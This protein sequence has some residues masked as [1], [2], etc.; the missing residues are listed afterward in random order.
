MTQSAAAIAAQRAPSVLVVLVV[1]D[2]A[3]WIRESLA[4]LAAQTYP[5]L[6]VMAVDNGST[7]GSGELLIQALGE[8][9]V[10][11]LPA[12]RGL[13]GAL[14]AAQAHPVANEADYLLLLH[15]DTAL[16][17]EGVTRMVEAAVGLPGMDRVGV[18]GAKVVDW[19]DPRQL[20][21]VGRSADRF[22]HPYSPLQPG[23][24]DQGQFDRVL[25]VL[26]VSSCAMLISRETWQR[27]GLF[28]ER[29]GAA[30]EDLDFCWRARVAGFRVLMTPLARARHRAAS[31]VADPPTARHHSARF[32]EDRAAIT[33]MLK[34]YSLLSLLWALPLSLGLGFVRL[35]FLLLARRFEEA[36]D[37]LAAWGWNVTHL[38]GTLSRRRKAQK[39]RRVNDRKLHRFMESAGLR[40]PR[41]FETAERMLEQPLDI[42]DD[43]ELPQRRRLRERTASLVATHPV[44][45][46]SFLGVLVGVAAMRSLWSPAGLAGG[47]LPAFPATASAF[48]AEMTS[49]FRTTG[50][51]GSM[52]AS[53]ALGGM[54]ALSAALF[55]ST[56]LAQ[57]AMVGGALPLAAILMY[58]ASVRLTKR[59]GPSVVAA[60]AYVGS[61]LTLWALSQGRLGL[62]V[63]LAVLP[64][65]AERLEVAFGPEGP[66]EQRWRFVAGLGVTLAVL[67]AFLPGAALAVVVLVLVQSLAGAQ[68]RRGLLLILQAAVAAMLLLLPF[69]LTLVSGRGTAFASQVGTTDVG[70]L[71]RLAFGP[72]PGTWSVG[73]FLPIAALIAFALVDAAHRGRAVRAMLAALAGLALA[74]LSAAG[75]LPVPVSDPTAYGA[76]AAVG[77]AMVIAYGLTSVVAW[78]GRESFGLRQIGTALLT[79]VLGAGLLLQALTAMVGGWAVGGPHE[80]PPAWAVVASAAKGD[81]RVLWVGAADGTPFPAPGG[82]PTGVVTAGDATL[83]YSLT[84]RDGVTALDV[85]R[86]LSGPGNAALKEALGQILSGATSHGGALLA[87]FGIRF[88]VADATR[89]PP[90]A[91]ALLQ[92]Q[93]DLDLVP[94]TGLAIYHNAAALP[95]AAILTVNDQ[96][97]AGILAG[98]PLDTAMLGP[99]HAVPMVRAPGGWD[100]PAG[101]GLVALA[102][103]FDG[104]W[105]IHGTDA[106]PQHAFGWATAFTDTKG[107]V[108]VRYGMQ[109]LRSIE[110]GLM[111]ILWAGA[112]WVTR[113]PVRR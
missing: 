12:D 34:N 42:E 89:L 101:S 25:E 84:D 36:F 4:A 39:A 8:G 80:V 76:L 37:L 16:D 103:E 100:G 20:R 52:A 10:V 66:A 85:G 17:P 68:R 51:G 48:F 105:R 92:D 55:G 88:V 95:P 57:K 108:A 26:C 78:L 83:E 109:W 49:G 70:R 54:G 87:P 64:A 97:Q 111:A 43:D 107:P 14:S 19:D 82:D 28:D 90:A 60:A 75:Y 9:R 22:G 63:T 41:W 2:A 56:T 110:V 13:G 38:P 94:A 81:F 113:K 50:L 1:R 72:G 59:Q 27:A 18:V 5:R 104:A 7:D 61:S 44:L 32:E 11:T 21:D 99:L 53:P 15:D 23:E 40:L 73:A 46:A 3:G 30:Y 62:L 6:A 74:W 45:V 35:V 69:V 29:I 65:V 33:A 102:T 77:E 79:V 106:K 67:V 47:V 24:I 98:T 96:G 58:R 91:S 71:A 86:P 31:A 93:I 112:L